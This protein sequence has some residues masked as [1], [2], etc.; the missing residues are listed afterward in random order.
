M[1]KTNKKLET[2]SNDEIKRVLT[3]TLIKYEQETIINYLN[4]FSNQKEIPAMFCNKNDDCDHCQFYIGEYSGMYDFAS[5]KVVNPH[6]IRRRSKKQKSEANVA[7]VKQ[8]ATEYVSELTDSE[9]F[10]LQGELDLDG[11]SCKYQELQHKLTIWIMTNFVLF[12]SN[13]HIDFSMLELDKH[14]DELLTY[15]LYCNDWNKLSSDLINDVCKELTYIK[16]TNHPITTTFIKEINDILLKRTGE[17]VD[18][19]YLIELALKYHV[20]ITI[21]INEIIVLCIQVHHFDL[22]DI[23]PMTIITRSQLDVASII[24]NLAQ[25]EYIIDYEYDC[26]DGFLEIYGYLSSDLNLLHDNSF[27]FKANGFEKLYKTWLD[28]LK[29]CSGYENAETFV[30]IV[31]GLEIMFPELCK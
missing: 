29:A 8:F 20:Y 10:N 30:N 21:P 13:M 9:L 31:N 16:L 22:N 18:F 3:D 25:D 23:Q 7:D 2:I 26:S 19:D 17:V 11:S 24:D 5:H 27:K 4:K 28:N 15:L 1:L 12:K 14:S 6:P